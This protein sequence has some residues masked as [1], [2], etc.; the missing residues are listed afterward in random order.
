MHKKAQ[1]AHDYIDHVIQKRHVHYDSSVT[2]GE[3]ATV[4]HETHQ[5]DH[6]IAQ[7]SQRKRDNYQPGLA[8]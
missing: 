7:L 3:R 1:H 5:E 4:S 2:S 6:F 8:T